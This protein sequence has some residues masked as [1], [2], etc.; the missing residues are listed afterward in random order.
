MKI[1]QKIS[2][3]T[4]SFNQ[5]PYIEQTICSVLDQNYPNLE[6][7]IIDGGSTDDTV[8]I[9]KKYESKLAYWVSETDKGQTD[10][11]NK[12]FAK[13]TG[14]IFNWINSDDYYELGCFE[15]I[16]S[17]FAN[18]AVQ[19]VCGKEWGFRD[20]DPSQKILH[21][22]SIICN[23]VY[24]TIRVGIIDQPCTF[25]RKI[26]IDKYFPLNISLHYTM[27]RQLWWRYLVEYGQG[28]ILEVDDVLTNFRLHPHSK[29]VCGA[30]K[31]EIEFDKLKLSLMNTLNAPD[32]LKQQVDKNTISLLF[33]WQIQVKDAHLIL[34]EFAS[35]YALRKYIKSEL[36]IAAQLIRL[37]KKW[38]GLKMT[39]NEWRLWI[40]CNLLPRFL[41]MQLKQVKSKI[42]FIY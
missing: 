18:P 14:D 39:K 20:E 37:V 27:D 36:E 40:S 9:I 10:A 11:I 42:S 24:E 34:A 5:G 8:E 28:A 25:F 35:F 32:I 23:N 22:G 17:L 4:P 41:L 13:C 38:K 7:I 26:N 6:Y 1:Y 3:V 2:I 12:G 31:M 33:N 21:P 19:I 16:N 29:T 30:D 15:K